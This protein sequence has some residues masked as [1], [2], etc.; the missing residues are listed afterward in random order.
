MGIWKVDVSSLERLLTDPLYPAIRWAMLSGMDLPQGLPG[1]VAT[2]DEVFDRVS[3][4][5]K[6]GRKYICGTPDMTAADIT[7]AAI[8]YP[9]VLPEEKAAVFASWDDELP[10]G[11]R[12]E[13]RHRRETPAGQFV[14]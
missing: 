4:L 11:F 12:T 2:V 5:L 10:E 7:F 6:D 3:T 1:F 13:V 8:A 14:L 9:L